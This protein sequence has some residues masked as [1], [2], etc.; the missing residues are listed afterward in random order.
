[1]LENSAKELIGFVQANRYE[2]NPWAFNGQLNKIYL[3][4]PYHRLGLGKKMFCAVVHRFI[5]AGINSM[6]LFS[7]ADNPSGYFY[8]AMK[9]ER[10]LDA[11][12]NF[13]GG[14]GWPDLTKITGL[15]G[16]QNE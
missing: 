6:L 9:G 11:R 5:A 13:H 3:L 7:E 8:E 4:W 1:M 14:Y 2:D 12:G 16:S 10:L 15:C